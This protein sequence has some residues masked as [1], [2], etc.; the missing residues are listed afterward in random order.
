MF[1]RASQ[2]SGQAYTEMRE[3][4]AERPPPAQTQ[5]TLT[6]AANVCLANQ[7]Y[8]GCHFASVRTAAPCLFVQAYRWIYQLEILFDTTL[9]ERDIQ[10]KRVT[11][12][13]CT[14]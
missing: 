1:H 8:P 5:R 4:A 2:A 10:I 12:T 11:L 9:A 6:L 7:H 3:A 14:A 13:S